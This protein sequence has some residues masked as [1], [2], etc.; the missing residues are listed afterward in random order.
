MLHRRVGHAD[1]HEGAGEVA[2][3]ERLLE[4][5][6]PADRLDAHVGAVAVGERADRLDRVGR[7]ASSRCAWRRT[8]RPLELRGSRSTAMI[9]VRAREARAGDRG[10]ADAA[11][12]EHRD[13]VAAADV[14]GVHRRAEAGHHAAAEQPGGL[15]AGARASTFVAWPAA[16][17]VFSA[18]APMPSAGES[19]VPS[20][21]R[22]LLGRVEGGEAVPR[23]AA[24]A[25]A[26]GAAHRAPVR[27]SRSRRARRRRRRGRPTST[28]PAASWPSR[29]GKSSLIAP[30]R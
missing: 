4:H 14:A 23:A 13:A 16:T 8:P 1:L 15:G 10:V 17:S 22:H 18:N 26:A 24:P 6:G 11:A 20:G 29:N 30:S 28:T 5:L 19:S 2:R 7:R 25:R 9:G 3:E 21:E 27:G 12:A